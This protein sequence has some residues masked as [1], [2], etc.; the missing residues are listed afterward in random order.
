M[1]GPVRFARLHRPALKL[2]LFEEAG[3]AGDLTQAD[4]KERGPDEPARNVAY[5]AKGRLTGFA[6]H[7]DVRGKV[8]LWVEQ[9]DG[10]QHEFRADP[11]RVR[12][13]ADGSFEVDLVDF[14]TLDWGEDLNDPTLQFFCVFTSDAVAT[15][16]LHLCI[17]PEEESGV[18]AFFGGLR[19]GPP[20]QLSVDARSGP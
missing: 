15:A 13:S 18:T 5:K 12:P 20:T 11:V 10:V 1:T 16:D 8:A 2:E 4:V 3:I 14:A 7:L 19:S 17:W 6:P 9:P